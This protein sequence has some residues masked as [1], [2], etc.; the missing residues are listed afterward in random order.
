MFKK[1]ATIFAKSELLALGVSLITGALF[2]FSS[3][4]AVFLGWTFSSLSTMPY[5]YLQLRKDN[6]NDQ[7]FIR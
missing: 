7:Y 3:G 4:L 2:G 1:A 6:K 5:I